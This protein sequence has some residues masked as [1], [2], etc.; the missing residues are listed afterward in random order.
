[1]ERQVGQAGV[2]GAADAVLGA[3][4][5]AVP[6]FQVEQMPALVLVAKQVIRRSS[7][8]RCAYR[9]LRQSCSARMGLPGK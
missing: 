5:A 7:N 6:Q 2:F 4:A 9:C 1:V 8:F 3:G